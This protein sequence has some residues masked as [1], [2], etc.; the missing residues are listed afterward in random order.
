MTI[1]TPIR[2]LDPIVAAGIAA[3]EVVERPASVVKELAENAL[4]AGATHVAVEIRQGGLELIRVTDD[5]HGIPAGELA[6]AFERHATNKLATLEDLE[7]LGTLGFRGEALPSIAAAGHVRMV[8]RTADADA[9]FIELEGGAMLKTGAEGAAP[10]TSVTV[11]ALFSSIPARLKYLRSV[12]AETGRVRQAVDNLALAYPH[13][14]FTFTADGKTTLRTTGD[15]RLL[16]AFS[17][18]HGAEI[19]GAMLEVAPSGNA[20]YPVHGL[21]GRP[22]VSR[23]NRSAIRIFVNGRPVQSRM[24]TAA[25]EEAYTGLLMEGRYPIAVVLL[26]VPGH[27]VDVNVH[28]NK[29]E[30]RFIHD[31]DAFASVQRSVR[32]ALAA[33]MPLGAEPAPASP[34][35]S[36]SYNGA[37]ST[38]PAFAF[39]VPAT[40]PTPVFPPAPASASAGDAPMPELRVL[41]QVSNTYIVAEGPDGMVLVDQ[42]A[43]HESVLFYR[44]LRQWDEGQ[45]EMQP[46]LEPLTLEFTPEQQE[47]AAEAMPMLQA[48]GFAVEPFGDGAWLLRAVPVMSRQVDAEK[49]LAELLDPAAAGTRIHGATPSHWAMAASIACHSAIRAGQTLAQEEMQELLHALE[50]GTD[51]SH[52]PHGRP[53]AIKLTTGML[54]RE[55]GRA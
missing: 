44:L 17:V 50:T 21:A 3:G 54:D 16:D 22:A 45:A 55:F 8:S 25:V 38:S 48:Y 12:G 1:P 49:M 43:A 5:G 37:L 7:S 27:E 47:A 31:G 32:A 14:A 2:T 23:P 28:P 11:E 42:H 19:A 36:L 10:G 51:P 15:G 53:A 24:L 41:G 26:E 46:L 34:S 29:R 18:I 52:C 40:T 35:S 20:A 6:L 13:V 4:D 33:D 9:A 39:T 30:V